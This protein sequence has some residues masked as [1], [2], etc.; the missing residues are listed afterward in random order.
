MAQE[1]KVNVLIVDDRPNNLAALEVLLDGLDLNFVRAYSGRDALRHLLR[2]DF[3]LILMDVQMPDMDGLETAA[4]IRQRDRNRR[5]P[6]MFLTAFEHQ[7]VQ[8]SRSYALGG[9]DFLVKPIVP[10]VLRSKVSVFAEL[11]RNAQM[12]R[13]Q[14]RQLRDQQQHEHEARLTAEKE[15]WEVGRLRA[16]AERVQEENRRKDEFLAMLAHELRNPLAPILNAIQI[17]NHAPPDAEAAAN[18]RDIIERQTR[19]MARLLDDLLDVSRITRGKIELRK[20]PVELAQLLHR[21]VESARPFIAAREHHL[22]VVLPQQAVWLNADPTRLEQVFANLLNNAAKY[23]EPGGRIAVLAECSDGQCSVRVLDTGVGMDPDM[24]HRAFELFVQ[25][26]SSLGRE[27]SGLGIGLTLV[28]QLMALHDGTVEAHSEGRG[29]GSEFVVRLPIFTGNVS[30]RS[31]PAGAE[32]SPA[33]WDRTEPPDGEQRRILVVDDNR[34]AAESL[35]MLLSLDGHDVC[36]VHD[37]PGAIEAARLHRPDVVF[38]DLGLPGMDGYQVARRIR[39]L[40][41]LGEMLLIAMTGYGQEDD[42][43]RCLEAGFDH[44]VV[45]PADPIALQDLFLRGRSR[46]AGSAGPGPDSSR[47]S[48]HHHLQEH[49]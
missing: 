27:Q 9:V 13:D 34:D 1:R 40:A 35:R 16:E 22:E 20:E 37:G 15:S 26:D 8:V 10:E 33:G 19:H 18:A 2:E 24:L 32:A 41:G 46:R 17:L 45:K 29:R 49:H 39:A 4:L 25:G 23:T 14:A 44:H 48:L 7:D 21:T 12:V 28:R 5:T 6:I 3:A 36:I 30:E 31:L 47:D 43:R 11:F 38:L 42:R